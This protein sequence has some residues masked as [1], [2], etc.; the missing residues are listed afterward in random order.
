MFTELYKPMEPVLRDSLIL[1]SDFVHQIK[2]DGIRGITY[3]EK[4]EMKIRTKNNSDVTSKYPELQDLKNH[5]TGNNAII[6]GEMVI[7]DDKGKPDFHKIL[8]RHMIQ[9]ERKIKYS[10]HSN[11]VFYIVF[12]LLYLNNHDLRRFKYSDRKELLKKYYVNG[13]LT[14]IT[15]DFSDGKSLFNLM[16]ERGMEGIVSKNSSSQYIA[17]KS[18][19]YWFKTKIKKTI[20]AVIGGVKLRN[21]LPVSLL[22]GIYDSNDQ[23]IY[24]GNASSGLKQNDLYLL[25]KNVTLLKSDTSPFINY[26]RAPN[27]QWLKPKVTCY[28]SYL[29]RN[30]H[31]HLRHPEVTGFSNQSPKEAHGEEIICQQ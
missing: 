11:P 16:K 10:A 25:K 20:L 12:D 28:I 7:L 23:L 27:T 3:I 15:D 18:H 2:W 21:D 6:D 1:H 19:D 31:G 17:G 8:A 24:I 5:F 14:A 4:S 30:S 13:N 29:E 26:L 22:L 9:S